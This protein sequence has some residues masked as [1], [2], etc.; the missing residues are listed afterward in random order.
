MPDWFTNRDYKECEFEQGGVVQKFKAS[1]AGQTDF[2]L[3]G[4]VVWT[5]AY[6][7][8]KYFFDSF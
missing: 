7:L 1:T 3:T 5:A 8:A 6:K 4:Q 2:D